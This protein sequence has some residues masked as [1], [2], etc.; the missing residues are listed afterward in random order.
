MDDAFAELDQGRA[1]RVMALLDDN[2]GGQVIVT[3]P[4]ESDIR[5]EIRT[6]EQWRIRG[7]MIE[8]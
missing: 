6:L 2:P 4:R 3:A 1:E 5:P 7:G 8:A